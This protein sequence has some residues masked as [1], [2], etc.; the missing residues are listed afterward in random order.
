MGDHILAIDETSFEHVTVAE[1]TQ[2]LKCTTGS[3][4]RLEIV[5]ARH[6]T[7]SS[8]HTR[9]SSSLERDDQHLPPPPPELL[10]PPIDDHA[11]NSNRANSSPNYTPPP[12][13]QQ[14]HPHSFV[15]IVTNQS[16]FRDLSSAKQVLENTIAG[17]VSRTPA[18]DEC[19]HVVHNRNNNHETIN[20][21][22]CEIRRYL[23]IEK[24]SR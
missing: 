10:N 19:D 21:L 23:P 13:L 5:P 8:Q 12:S 15:P 9:S 14:R 18:A 17:R 1:A 2:I 11:D 20:L 24:P 3:H 4:V 6:L 7:S 16:T 22:P